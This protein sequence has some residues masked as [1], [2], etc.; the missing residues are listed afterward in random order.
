M[1]II[2]I[3]IYF[4][5][6]LAKGTPKNKLPNFVGWARCPH[7]MI[8]GLFVPHLMIRGLFGPSLMIRG[9][10]GPHYKKFL[11]IFLIGSP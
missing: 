6:R 1:A 7:L 3:D 5:K 9:L 4:V 11:G 2:F 10:F 8:R